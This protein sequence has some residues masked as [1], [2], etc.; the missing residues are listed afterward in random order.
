MNMV[1]IGLLLGSLQGIL[2]AFFLVTRSRRNAPSGF[3]LGAYVF[4]ISLCILFPTLL[5]FDSDAFIHVLVVSFPF[6]FL[7]GPFFFFYCETLVQVRRPNKWIHFIPSILVTGSM[8]PLFT[9]NTIEKIDF[10]QSM[11]ALGTPPDLMAWWAGAVVHILVYL[12]AGHRT[13]SRHLAAAE[14]LYSS[15]DKEWFSRIRLFTKSNVAL[16]SLY[17][18]F[19]VMLFFDAFSNPFGATDI[20]FG[21][22][23]G[24]FNY[25]LAYRMMER[26]YLL[27]A[28]IGKMNGSEKYS[29]SGLT[30]QM[31][32]TYAAGLMKH[33]QEQRPYLDPGLSLLQLAEALDM[34]PKH[35]SQVINDKAGTTF[36]DFVNT[37]RVKEAERR[38]VDPQYAHLTLLAI[39]LSCGF[40]SKSTFN[41]AFRRY[42]GLTPSEYK[43]RS[44]NI[45]P[46]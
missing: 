3:F 22:L 43:K 38:I 34:N 4:V 21:Y 10:L 45:S 25:T 13:L 19:Y 15:I 37:W 33:M 23:I 42:T 27:L 24:F 1:V 35:L 31:A 26:P 8:V 12:N 39:G 30:D 32:D 28:P 36:Y 6:L 9:L 41:S 17:L 11:R 5:R 46:I 18:V 7:I 20:L 2:L 29:K 14:N 16:W 40:N 44:Q